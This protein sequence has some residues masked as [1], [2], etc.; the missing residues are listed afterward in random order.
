[1]K[2]KYKYVAYL[3]VILSFSC[4]TDSKNIK[5]DPLVKVYEYNLYPS[6]IYEIVPEGLTKE[7]SAAFVKSYINNWIK[8]QVLLYRAELNLKEEQKKFEKQ[9]EN[10]R[11]SLIIY[12]YENELLKQKLDTFVSAEEIKEYYENN[13]NNFELKDD[14]VKAIYIKV[15]KSAPNQKKIQKIY[16]SN[17]KKDKKELEEFCLQFAEQYYLND[18]TWILFE[19]LSQHLPLKI[20]NPSDF[21]QK[22]KNI[23]LQDSLFNYYLSIKQYKIK[24]NLSPLSFEIQNIRN[25]IINK[26]K[27]KLLSQLKENLY[28]EAEEKNKIKIYEPK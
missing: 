13:K 3:F 1:M 20:Y 9:L 22:N 18:S 23:Q 7:D 10:Y 21:L 28:K 11:K 5:E 12:T 19:E 4:V 24:N 6:D 14:I 17:K 26:R 25:I 16:A 27:L 15:N 2:I 8:E